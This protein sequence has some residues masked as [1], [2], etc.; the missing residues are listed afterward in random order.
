MSLVAAQTPEAPPTPF[1]PTTLPTAAAAADATTTQDDITELLVQGA[2]LLRMLPEEDV[3]DVARLLQ[4]PNSPVARALHARL[5][6]AAKNGGGAKQ[7]QYVDIFEEPPRESEKLMLVL[8]AGD[9]RALVTAL[10]LFYL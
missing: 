3:E 2:E 6:D 9:S 4:R 1:Q 10:A 8:S 5:V 7:H